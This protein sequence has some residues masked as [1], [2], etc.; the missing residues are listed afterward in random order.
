MFFSFLCRESGAGI[1]EHFGDLRRQRRNDRRVEQRI[2]T[3]KQDTADHNGND[4]L[5]A[6]IDIALTGYGRK[7]GSCAVDLPEKEPLDDSNH[8]F[9][10]GSDCVGDLFKKL[11]HD[12]SPLNFRIGFVLFFW[13]DRL[14]SDYSE[15]IGIPPLQ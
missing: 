8:G 1:A 12:N 13:Y 10:C 7:R 4:D 2:Q 14:R 9:N 3:R 11:F 6:G 15:D 5:H